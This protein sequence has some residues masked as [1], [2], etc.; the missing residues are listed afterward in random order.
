MVICWMIYVTILRY[1]R[2]SRTRS[3][4]FLY[5]RLNFNNYLRQTWR[6]N[7]GEF[8]LQPVNG[9]VFWTKSSCRSREQYVFSVATKD[10]R[11]H[12][13]TASDVWNLP[14]IGKLDR[15]D[16]VCCL[17]QPFLS[18]AFLICGFCAFLV[19]DWTRN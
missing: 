19:M 1:G 10:L 6:N 15:I 18:L 17:I 16:G 9:M 4:W 14:C 13:S 7:Q 11:M 8:F 2:H 5:N 3:S 12:L